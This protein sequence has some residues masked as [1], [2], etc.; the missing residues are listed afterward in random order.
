MEDTLNKVAQDSPGT[1]ERLRSHCNRAWVNDVTG[2][3]RNQLTDLSPCITLIAAIAKEQKDV[4]DGKSLLPASLMTLL[5]AFLSAFQGGL[6][7]TF[8]YAWATTVREPFSTID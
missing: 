2:T 6:C 4:A 3:S 1:Q 5:I 8:M 7:A